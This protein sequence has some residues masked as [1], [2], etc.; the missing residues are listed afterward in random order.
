ME[1]KRRK[2]SNLTLSQFAK[3]FYNYAETPTI[4]N[5]AQKIKSVVDN[6]ANIK[7]KTKDNKKEGT[8]KELK[9][10]DSPKKASNANLTINPFDTLEKMV[11]LAKKRPK[12]ASEIK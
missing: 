7:D 5:K 10:N 2:G 8:T 6:S 9:T 1:M 3:Y 4:E 12:K 11:P